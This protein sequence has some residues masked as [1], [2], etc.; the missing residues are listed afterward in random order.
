MSKISTST[1]RQKFSEILSKAEF[2]GERTILHRRKKPIA[3]VVPI[4]DLELIERYEDELDAR[5]LKKA[6]KEKT[7]PWEQ[8]KQDLGL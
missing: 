1:A 8:L 2:A 4:E 3:A 6:R 5:L 7:I